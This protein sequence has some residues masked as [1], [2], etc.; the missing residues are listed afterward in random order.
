VLQGG[1]FPADMTAARLL[2]AQA[3][4]LTDCMRADQPL[5]FKC[6]GKALPDEVASMLVHKVSG[7]RSDLVA[8][9][10]ARF[11]EGHADGVA[12]RVPVDPWHVAVRAWLASSE[13]PG[14]D[15]ARRAVALENWLAGAMSE[16]VPQGHAEVA[17]PNNWVYI[18]DGVGPDSGLARRP[19]LVVMAALSSGCGRAALS[20][21]SKTCLIGSQV[22]LTGAAKR[23]IQSFGPHP[24]F[25][26]ASRGSSELNKALS[27]EVNVS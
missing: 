10:M 4:L 27:R 8:T 13:I 23:G 3:R 1:S 26:A 11:R 7:D 5:A 17:S 24:L 25:L 22:V 21:I 12:S 18:D 19:A 6:L 9:L 2:M 14:P 20:A 16:G 15:P